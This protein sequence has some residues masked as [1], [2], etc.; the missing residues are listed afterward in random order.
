MLWALVQQGLFADPAG[1]RPG[2]L[3]DPGRLAAGGSRTPAG[4]RTRAGSRTPA[5]SRT[6][7]ARTRAGSRQRAG[8]ASGQPVA[9]PAADP[10]LASTES[11]AD[12]AQVLAEV[13]R[14]VAGLTDARLNLLLTDGERIAATAWGD[15]LCWRDDGTGVVVAS[16]PHDDEAGWNEVPDR[17]VLAVSLDPTG[18]PGE[19]LVEA[20]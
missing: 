7:P 12:P 17:T 6:G 8:A 2:R 10:G 13:V 5:G 11:G 15:T 3:A 1:S 19:V 18:S 14:R 9:E 4:S 20:I 16:E